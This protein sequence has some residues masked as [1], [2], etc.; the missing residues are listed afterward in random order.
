[1]TSSPSLPLET[2]GRRLLGRLQAW[3]DR[4]AWSRY[5]FEFLMFGL[6]QGWACLFGGLMLVLLMGTALLWPEHAPVARYDFLVIAAVAIQ[7]AML[8][9]KLETW[10][11]AQVI[12]P[13]IYIIQAILRSRYFKVS[14]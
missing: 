11:E 2:W 8:W 6:K 7:A 5:G 9:L 1:M 10:E 3:A 4:A 14:L 13:D 12:L